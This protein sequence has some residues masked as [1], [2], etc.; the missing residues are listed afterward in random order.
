LSYSYLQKDL[1]TSVTT[2]SLKKRFRLQTFYSMKMNFY[3]NNN[4]ENEEVTVMLSKSVKSLTQIALVGIVLAGAF[5]CA[6]EYGERE[7]SLREREGIVEREGG[8]E[9]EDV[10]EREIEV[11]RD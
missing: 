1:I 3:S 2:S 7:E 5:A 8:L 10:E 4:S 9:R 11:E 6:P